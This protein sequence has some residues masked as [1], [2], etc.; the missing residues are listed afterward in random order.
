[1]IRIAIIAPTNFQSYSA[2]LLLKFIDNPDFEVVSVFIYKFSW[3]RWKIE[4]KRDGLRILKKILL[5]GILREATEIEHD[6]LTPKKYLVQRGVK[7]RLDKICRHH[8]I[9]LTHVSSFNSKDLI[10]KMRSLSLDIGI[11]G[12]GGL[13]RGPFL[14]SFRYGV[15]NCHMGILPEYR[16]MDVVEWPLLLEDF[17][18]VG[19]TCHFMDEGIDTGPI[20]K[21]TKVEVQKFQSITELRSYLSSIMLTS[22]YDTVVCFSRSEIQPRPQLKESGKQFFV[23]HSFLKSQIRIP[24]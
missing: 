16:G 4:F 15:I 13:L 5:K 18:N 24:K 21:V 8:N 17:E 9:K 23:M 6:F 22:M 20:L 2:A 12:G 11:F 1:M 3:K 19:V 14:D 10:I 7:S